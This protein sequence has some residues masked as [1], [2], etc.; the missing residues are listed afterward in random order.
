MSV[1]WF[2]IRRAKAECMR[3]KSMMSSPPGKQ[4]LSHSIYWLVALAF[5]LRIA[6][7]LY[8]G[9]DDFW[10]NG[11]TFFF[12]MA[13]NIAAGKGIGFDGGPPTAFSVPLYLIFLAGLTMGHKW[14]LPILLAESLIGAATVL[15]AAWLA[16]EMFGPS[17]AIL[18]AGITALYPYYVIH[19]TAL[20][21]TSL[22][23]LLTLSAVI[24]LRRAAQ[25]GSVAFAAGSGLILGL[26]ILTRSTI[27]PFAAI[28][29][30]WLVWRTRAS[31]A[32]AIRQGALC[33]LMFTAIVSPWLWR[34]YKLTGVP[35]LATEAGTERWNGNN[36]IL[37]R[38]YPEE[39]SD[40]SKGEA[41]DALT[42]D[43]RRQLD[44]SAPTRRFGIAGF[45]AAASNTC[46][47]IHCSRYSMDCARLA[48]ASADYPAPPD[49]LAE[50]SPCALVWHSNALRAV[51]YVAETP[52]FERELSDLR[53]LRGVL[54]RKRGLLRAHPPPHISRRVLDHT[55]LRPAE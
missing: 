40:I 31:M 27:A 7:R 3:W 45:C 46:E 13:Q 17:A 29:P 18:A 41:F 39:S 12:D 30:V 37:F 10:I 11:Y 28:C 47:R 55:R 24:V 51:R 20:Q 54:G 25:T 14:F 2:S 53:A 19:N 33:A 8:S 52:S 9:R 50:F 21:E 23:T 43:D 42:P 36:A 26:D 6:A 38:H 16:R 5:A 48:P 1:G 35:T 44:Q 49:A 22:F 15:W 4:K 34:N 32:T